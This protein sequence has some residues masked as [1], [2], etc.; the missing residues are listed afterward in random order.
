MTM[1]NTLPSTAALLL[2]VL[3]SSGCYHYHIQGNRV[4]PA[5]EARS[6]TQVAYFW[7]LMQPDDITPENC[8]VKV[9]LADVTAHT[10]LGHILISTV[11]LGI[12]SIQRIE[13]RCAKLPSSG[14]DL[15]QGPTKEK[16]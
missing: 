4:T 12:V 3:S 8:P 9:P 16:G 14:I 15:V 6:Q 5:T 10:N 7:G 11:T 13:W 1:K 2:A